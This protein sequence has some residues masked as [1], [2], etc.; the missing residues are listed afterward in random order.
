MCFIEYDKIKYIN[1]LG[2]SPDYSGIAEGKLNCQ[3][4]YCEK[5][6]IIWDFIQ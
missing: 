5:A 2:Q 3:V 1:G 4:Y 6:N